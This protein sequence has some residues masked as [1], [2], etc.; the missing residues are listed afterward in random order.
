MGWRD[1]LQP[2]ARGRGMLLF[3]PWTFA[4]QLVEL[5]R[6]VRGLVVKGAPPP[7]GGPAV[8]TGM[9]PRGR[10][11]KLGLLAGSRQIKSG[12]GLCRAMWGQGQG[13]AQGCVGGCPQLL[14]FDA[15]QEHS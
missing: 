11:V 15:K 4:E 10:E 8:G 13:P 9:S 1:V 6:G 2:E 3:P 7:L 12:C 14:L 5:F